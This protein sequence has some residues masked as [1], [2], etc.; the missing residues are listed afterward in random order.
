[1]IKFLAL[2]ATIVLA[3]AEDVCVDTP[4]WTDNSGYDCSFYVGKGICSMGKLHRNG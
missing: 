1:M 2:V 3:S 4:A